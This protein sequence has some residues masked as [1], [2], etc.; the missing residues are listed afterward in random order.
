VYTRQSVQREPGEDL[1]SCAVQREHCGMFIASQKYEGWEL[2]RTRFDDV[3]QSG[4]TLE[5]PALQ[6]LLRACIDGQVD[7][8]V[9]WKLDRLT[10]K[11]EDWARLAEFFE[12]TGVE[13]TLA[14][15][16]LDGAGLSVTHFVQHVLAS[17]AEYERELIGERLRDARAGR[18]ALGLRASGRVPFGYG[19]DGSTRQ[20]VPDAEESAVVREIFERAARG[21]SAA[22][23]ARWLNEAGRMTRGTKHR[24]GG[25]WSGR[26]VLQLLRNPVYLGKRRVEGELIAAAHPAIV[27]SKI[28]E[29]VDLAIG[30]RRTSHSRPRQRLLASQNDP[31]MLRGILHCGDCGRPMTT[32]SS[33]AVSLKRPNAH[34]RYYRCRETATRA[35]CKPPVQVAA[36]KT[37]A[38]VLAMLRDPNIIAAQLP[39]VA[40]LLGTLRPHWRRMTRADRAAWVRRLLWSAE[41]K[42]KSARLTLIFDQIGV[43]Q[44]LD[45][46][47]PQVVDGLPMVP[48][49][50]GRRRP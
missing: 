12:Q 47:T 17:F 4:A 6:R 48:K 31:Y 34:P 11:L 30:A 10:R 44:L 45:D 46:E 42:P 37:E 41:W 20:L 8:V 19:V 7:R 9:V 5:R 23:I 33:K 28:A 14:G 13:L 25:R 49:D 32:S 27:D 29:Q 18:R 22:A 26:T 16:A 15:Q 1:S 35:A 2:L 38:D 40:A 21:E 50:D 43:E 24:A 39:H 3:G 36:A